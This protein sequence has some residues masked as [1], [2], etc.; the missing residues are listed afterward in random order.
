MAVSNDGVNWQRN[1]NNPVLS[2][3][4][5]WEGS[6]IYYPSVVYENNIFKMVYMNTDA[7]AF[8][9]A[10]SPD[11][12]NWTKSSS[13]PFFTKEDTHNNWAHRDIA[14][15]YIFKVDNEYRIYYSGGH[16]NSY[17]YSIGFVRK[18]GIL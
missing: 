18:F 8:G 10:E 4:Q 14:Y 6:G 1:I 9:M 12:F 13:N 11:G 7:T 17:N 5:G 2:A 15:P 3:T 16:I